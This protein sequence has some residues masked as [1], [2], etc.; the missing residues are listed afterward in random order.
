[1]PLPCATAYRLLLC[2][3]LIFCCA[4][5]DFMIEY[6]GAVVRHSIADL[7]ERTLYNG[8]VG[9]GTYVFSLDELCVV[10]ATRQGNMAHLLNHSCG[11][12]CYSKHVMV[13][14][15]STSQQRPHVVIC[16]KQDIA[17]GEEL[18]YDYRFSGDDKLPCNCGATECRGFVNKEQD[19]NSLLARLEL[20]PLSKLKPL[21]CRIVSSAALPS[22]NKKI[23]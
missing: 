14:D 16:A 15:E 21:I 8:M 5:E 9:A 20:A 3:L 22:S 11:S 19:V 2:S 13:W 6:V 4:V 12:N 1:M 23:A 10:D 18:T 7:R 17:D